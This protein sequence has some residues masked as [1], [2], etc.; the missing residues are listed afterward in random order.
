MAIIGSLM[1]VGLVVLITS[2][3]PTGALVVL[4]ITLILEMVITV[5]IVIPPGPLLVPPGDTS[6]QRT[7]CLLLPPEV[8][9]HLLL[10]KV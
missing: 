5:V 9:G 7:L 8:S 2:T 10:Q 3:G 1:L 4:I 6:V